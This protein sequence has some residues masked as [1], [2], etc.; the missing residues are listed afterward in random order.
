MSKLFKGKY[1]TDTMRKQ[2]WNYAWRG[3]YFITLV[4]KDRKCLFGEIINGKMH[5]SELGKIAKEE[6]ENTPSIR[7][8]MNLRLDEFQV[9]PD[10]FHAIIEIQKNPYNLLINEISFSRPMVNSKDKHGFSLDT[11]KLSLNPKGEFGPQKKN[12]SS[13]IRGYKSAV[14][15]GCREIKPSFAWQSGYHEALIPNDESL[16]NI[17]WYIR[18]NPK[19]WEKNH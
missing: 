17:R 8:D 4:I 15:M 16:E 5:L 2:Y 13:I 7:P 14:T 11:W 3:K 6:W 1:R 18:H 10:H 19:N 9:M 12:L